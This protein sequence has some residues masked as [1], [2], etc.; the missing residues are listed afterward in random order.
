MSDV[1]KPLRP[2]KVMTAARQ[3]P[4]R[5][6]RP[7]KE[8]VHAQ[9]TDAAL[10]AASVAKESWQQL[11][12]TDRLF[13]MK[14]LIVVSWVAVSVATLV[15]ACPGSMRTGNPLGAQLVISRVADHPVYMIKN[16]GRSTWRDVVVVVNKRF[17]AAA[18][19]IE[20]GNN[21]TF[22]P[23]QLL[24]D[25]GAVAPADLKMADLE[26]RTSEGNARLMEGERLR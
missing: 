9:V 26:L 14:A 19:M 24:G 7:L 12:S 13:R 2:L 23:R 4:A 11:R 16:E 17:R 18:A 20:P 5:D 21:L 3:A 15:V 22:G 6:A 25:N 8:R 1:G 10:N